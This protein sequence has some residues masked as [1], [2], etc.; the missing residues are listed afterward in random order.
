MIYWKIRF[1]DGDHVGEE[2]WLEIEE[3]VRTRIFLDDQTEITVGTSYTA[4]DVEPTP[5]S[6]AS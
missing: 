6:W 5:P 3:N 4:I 2:G 1:D